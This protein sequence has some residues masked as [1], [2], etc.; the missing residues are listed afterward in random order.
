M[1][2]LDSSGLTGRHGGPP[3]PGDAC[4]REA[5]YMAAEHARRNDPVLTAKY[6]RLMV[7]GGKHHTSALCHIATSL[8]TRIAACWRRNDHYQLRDTDG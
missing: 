2:R 4:L 3:K 6:H 7:H 1:P 5:L 8:L